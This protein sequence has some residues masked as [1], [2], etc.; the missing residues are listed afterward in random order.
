LCQGNL[1]GGFPRVRRYLVTEGKEGDFSLWGGPDGES[2]V[3]EKGRVGKRKRT[4]RFCRKVDPVGNWVRKGKETRIGGGRKRRVTKAQSWPN[5]W[6]FQ[7]TEL[8]VVRRTRKKG[9]QFFPLKG[10]QGLERGIH[11]KK[12]PWRTQ[13]Q[14]QRSR[15]GSPGK[16]GKLEG[17]RLKNGGNYRKRSVCR[18][19]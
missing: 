6:E 2:K 4:P 18:Q 14:S 10:W 17:K 12:L 15:L 7:F 5:V 11:G 3:W 1:R 13:N 8:W 9:S 19:A 16:K